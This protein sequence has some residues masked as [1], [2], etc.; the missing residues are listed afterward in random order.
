MREILERIPF[1]RELGLTLDVASE[2]AVT[3]TLPD[4]TA[5]RNLA[6]T[7]HA[8]ALFTF[9]ETV[10]GVA[11]GLKTLDR[12]FPFAR[13]AQIRYRR[14][15]TGAV[16]GHAKV[17]A[18]EAERVLRELDRNGR[19]ELTVSVSLQDQEGKAVAELTVEYAF[20]PLG[21]EKK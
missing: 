18:S 7:V 5:A 17:E 6:G 12:A 10:A 9:G 2:G 15:A 16:L 3:M 20:R 13:Q 21:G 19:S 8:G 4:R 11:A 1:S 14:P